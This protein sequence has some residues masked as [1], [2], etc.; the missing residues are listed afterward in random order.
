VPA[1][2]RTPFCGT[3]LGT[4]NVQ[5]TWSTGTDVTEYQLWLGLNG[6]GSSDLYVSGWLTTTTTTVPSL[7]GKGVAVYAR[8]YSMVGGKTQ[9][10]G[11]TFTEGGTPAAM[12]SPASGSVLGTSE[13]QFTWTPG[14][15]ATKYQLWLGLS[16]PGSSD[17]YVS[18]WLTAPTTSTTVTT[19]PA[20]GS[21]VYARLY[22]DVEGVIEYND[23]TYVEQ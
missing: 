17:L 6:P 3:V 19:L 9:Y 1:E 18:G 8:L 5:F 15:D 2:I 20:H 11:C 12:I 23:Y 14:I 16:G 21:T 10:F 7:P 13:V 22:S 4:S